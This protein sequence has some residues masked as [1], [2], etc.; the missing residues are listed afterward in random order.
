VT[1]AVRRLG[2]QE[3]ARLRDVRLASLRDAPYAFNS[4]VD[5][6][7]GEDAAAWRARL[8]AQA[9]FVA[10]A[11]GAAVGVVAGGELRDPD[12]D[13]RTVRALWVAAPWRGRDVAGPLLDAVVAWARADGAR[14]LRLWALDGATRARSFYARYGFAV[15]DEPPRPDHPAMTRYELTL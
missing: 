11:D 14:H 15:R 1:V 9:W 13:V 5:E 12:P 8:A 4:T 6:L 7:A 10:E 3:W 2:T